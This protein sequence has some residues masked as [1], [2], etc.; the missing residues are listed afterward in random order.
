MGVGITEFLEVLDAA[1]ASAEVR[2]VRR[3]ARKR[4]LVLPLTVPSLWGEVGEPL[5]HDP[6]VGARWGYTLAQCRTFREVILAAAREDAQAT[7][8]DPTD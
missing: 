6:E 7:G 2:R 4:S 8:L 1:I 3:W 5:R